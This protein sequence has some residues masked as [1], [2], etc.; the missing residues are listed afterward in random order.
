MT[1]KVEKRFQLV[2]DKLPNAH[3]ND[4]LEF[5]KTFE[6]FCDASHVGIDRMLSQESHL[7]T[8]FS[9]KLNE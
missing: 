7:I 8:F 2:K 4:L 3:V 6:V 1:L 9:E 5:G